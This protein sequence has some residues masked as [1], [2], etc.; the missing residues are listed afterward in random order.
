[1]KCV[2]ARQDLSACDIARMNASKMAVLCA[3]GNCPH[4]NIA[5]NSRGRG[6]R[7]TG[8][9]GG[10]AATGDRGAVDLTGAK[11]LD[12]SGLAEWTC[13]TCGC[14]HPVVLSGGIPGTRPGFI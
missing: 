8:D 7:Y 5:T 11:P 13:Q 9:A 3:L 4:R 14:I 2:M 6:L 10:V 12:A 1:M